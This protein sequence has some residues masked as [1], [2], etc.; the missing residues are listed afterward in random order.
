MT[1]LPPCPL[2]RQRERHGEN[3]RS[4]KEITEQQFPIQARSVAAMQDAALLWQSA[5]TFNI[6]C[7]IITYKH[8]VKETLKCTPLEI[9]SPM[10]HFW[11]STFHFS[12]YLVW[13]PMIKYLHCK[14]LSVNLHG[15]QG[16]FSAWNGK[17]LNISWFHFRDQTKCMLN[18]EAVS[19][20]RDRGQTN[21]SCG[22]WCMWA[23]NVNTEKSSVHE[24]V[25]KKMI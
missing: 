12:L 22:C 5:T 1:S 13:V 7:C 15:Q 14:S 23:K 9:M 24:R 2:W 25:S 21:W 16:K 17:P 11:Y 3:L 19:F 20:N 6:S 18:C 10:G 4:T 8:R